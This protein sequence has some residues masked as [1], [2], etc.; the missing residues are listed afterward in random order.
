V[1]EIVSAFQPK[2]E[3]SAAAVSID[4]TQRAPLRVADLGKRGRGVVAARDL[5]AGEL[6]E[7]APVILVPEADRRA[8]DASALGNYIFM[9][10]HGGP[11][12]DV[13]RP[14]GR[15]AIVLGFASLVNHSDRP[16]CRFLRHIEALALD[17]IAL[18]D[19][20]AGEELTFDYGMALWFEP[21]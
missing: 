7:R 8:V 18:R 4:S 11:D 6:V 15:A 10:E 17:L 14:H 9:W 12:E 16:N 21:A 2:F 19:I 13:Y 3:T 5:A 20:A 1:G